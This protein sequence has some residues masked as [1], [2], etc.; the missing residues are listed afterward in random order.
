MKKFFL[1]LIVMITLASGCKKI[2]LCTWDDCQVTVPP[3]ETQAVQTYLTNNGLS[4]TSHC[5][6]MFYRIEAPGAGEYPTMCNNISVHYIGRLTDGSIFDRTTTEPVL[7]D[8][9][10]MITGWK[11][12]MPRVKPGGRVVLYIPP[13]LGYGPYEQRD[14]SGNV[15]IPANSILIFEVDLL[16]VQ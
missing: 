13:S 9:S 15:V 10:R 3:Q 8:L 2:D 4:A 5:S 12:I 14:Q 1:P 11:N 16:S 7:L 6:G